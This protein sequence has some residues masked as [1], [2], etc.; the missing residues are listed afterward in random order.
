[1]STAAQSKDKLFGRAYELIVMPS[2]AAGGNQDPIIISSSAWEPEAL[3]ITFEVD[4]P[5][6]KS[7]WFARIC[8]YNTG[9]TLSRNLLVP[10][11]TVVLRAGYQNPGAGVIFRGTVFQ[12][13][14][15]RENVVDQKITLMCY[16]GLKETI[17]NFASFSG[18]PGMTQAALIQSM[19]ESANTPMK[20]GSIDT[21]ALS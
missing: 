5:G 17:A 7:L 21:T 1:M 2:P 6:Y 19:A 3:R 9:A 18:S 8:I 11:A 12:P 16:T 15:E 10:G 14:F 13:M 20:L 4:L